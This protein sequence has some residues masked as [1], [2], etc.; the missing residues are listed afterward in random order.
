MTTT[1]ARYLNAQYSDV[2]SEIRALFEQIPQ[3]RKGLYI[4]GDVG[5]GKTHIAYALQREWEK[6][7]EVEVIVE[8]VPEKRTKQ[9]TTQFWNMTEFLREIKR[10]F[11]LPYGQK[12]NVEERLLDHHGLLFLDDVGSERMSE[13]V[14]ETFYHL[15]NHR[16]NRAL[17][18]IMTSNFSLAE[19]AERIGDRTASRIAESCDVIQLVGGDRR[20]TKTNKIILNV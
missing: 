19:Q 4:H 16:Y 1:P 17:P 5:T 12:S 11:D 20:I 7:R 2:P 8:G 15:I 3:T 10:D 14:S 18:I 6:P 13:W 9:R